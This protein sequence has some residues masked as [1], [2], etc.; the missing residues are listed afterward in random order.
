M[1]QPLPPSTPEPL[2]ADLIIP[3]LALGL[4]VYFFFSIAGSAWEAKA[5]G[6][7]IGGTLVVL[8][9]LQV[10]RI[11]IAVA[12]GRARLNLDPL[13]QPYAL[14][15]RR[16]ALVVITGLFIIAMPALGLTLALLLAMLAA[17]YLMGVRRLA[18]LV[19]T[20]VGAAVA[21]YLMFFVA[22]DSDFPRGPVERLIAAVFQSRA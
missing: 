14:L 11:G 5:N 2:G 13:L 8:V 7:M 12:R 3:T 1:P 15:P 16:V 21:A 6:L 22:L 4:A 10:L 19:W 17:L 18:P 20:A 9:A